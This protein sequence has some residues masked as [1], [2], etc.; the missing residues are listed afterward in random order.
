MVSG[1]M[2]FEAGGDCAET[3]KYFLEI[4]NAVDYA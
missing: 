1:W 4:N 3:R 2:V